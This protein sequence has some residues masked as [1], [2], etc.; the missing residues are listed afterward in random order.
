MND[1]TNKPKK[2][3]SFFFALRCIPPDGQAA[4]MRIEALRSRRRTNPASPRTP[5][6]LR[7]LTATARPDGLAATR[8]KD[9][10]T[11]IKKCRQQA[12]EGIGFANSKH[13]GHGTP[14]D[15]GEFG[16]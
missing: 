5:L 8:K 16:S 9:L 4:Q 14:T 2:H 10:A 1:T 3:D 15:S 13:H 12:A 11:R 7:R 6:L